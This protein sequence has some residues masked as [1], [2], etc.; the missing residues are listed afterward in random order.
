MHVYFI[1]S[2]IKYLFVVLYKDDGEDADKD[3][4]WNLLNEYISDTEEE[5]EFE[6]ESIK[7]SSV[8]RQ[9]K[10]GRAPVYTI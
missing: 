7:V 5:L 2:R 10:I 1:Y 8:N 3:K 6:K 9:K 4:D